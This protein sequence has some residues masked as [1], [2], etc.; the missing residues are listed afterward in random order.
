[1]AIIRSSLLALAI[2]GLALNAPT[3]ARAAPDTI[4]QMAQSGGSVGGRAGRGRKDLSGGNKATTGK[5]KGSA[6]PIRKIRR[7]FS[8]TGRWLMRLKCTTGN[9][10]VRATFKQTSATS[11]TG[12]TLGL[13]TG[14]KSVISNGRIAGN[15]ITFT[16][17][18]VNSVIPAGV[19]M[20]ARV[21]GRRMTGTEQG[22]LWS[23]TFTAR[24][25]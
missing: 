24:K 21:T 15:R 2:A 17:R 7:G 22:P 5:P 12:T 16:R 4:F 23:C 25:Q 20:A 8:L 3:P 9:F 6:A 18:S 14:Y 11:F 19:R 10:Q 1:M 13:T